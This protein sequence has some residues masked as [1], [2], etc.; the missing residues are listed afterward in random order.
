MQ[1]VAHS[2][3]FAKKV[4]VPQSVGREFTKFGGGAVKNT[5]RMNKL[6]EMGRL[7]AEKAKT[8]KGKKNLMAEKKRVIGDLKSMKS[9]G[10]AYVGGGTIYDSATKTS[11]P[12]P[13]PP[14]SD[15]KSTSPMPPSKRPPGSSAT[16]PRKIRPLPMPPSRMMKSGGLT[17]GHKAADGVAKKGRT[18][19]KMVTMKRGGGYC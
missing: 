4:G 2:P 11:R 5:S 19:T 9:G 16:P 8:L 15:M 3:K 14:K 17:A 18:Q 1:A 10:K 6:E 12:A 7:N 13:T